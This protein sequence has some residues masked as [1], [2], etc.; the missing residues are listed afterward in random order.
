M[1]TQ[2]QPPVFFVVG[3]PTHGKT[4]TREIL[5]RLT[6]LKGG[7]CSDVIYAFLAARHNTTVEKLREIPK[8]DL[9][10]RL[11]AAGDFLCG[12]DGPMD[13]AEKPEVDQEVFRHPSALIR[14]LYMNGYNVI[15]G[16]RR[17]LELQHAKD[18]LD[19]CGV[20]QLTIHIVDPRKPVPQDNSEDLSDLADEKILNDGTPEELEAKLKAILERRYPAKPMPVVGEKTAA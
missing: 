16:V 20:E 1:Y 13:A 17:R 3:P 11:I 9:R 19:W 10:P 5:A 6:R 2:T 18:R 15:D 8:E 14:T 12:M 4:T 7:S